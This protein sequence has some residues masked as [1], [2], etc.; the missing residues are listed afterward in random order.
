MAYQ[1]LQRASSTP[2]HMKLCVAQN[3][4]IN[5]QE[6]VVYQ[7]ERV[8]STGLVYQPR[9]GEG[10]AWHTKRWASSGVPS[11]ATRIK[12]CMTYD[13]LAEQGVSITAGRIKLDVAYSAQSCFKHNVP[14]FGTIRGWLNKDDVCRTKV[15]R[16]K[17]SVVHPHQTRGI[18]H[19]T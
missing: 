15:R 17:H 10:S 3:Y 19:T 7:S 5:D 16:I 2:W 13:A 18:S 12:P 8:I 1:T 9:R 14:L 11:T 6:G 4:V